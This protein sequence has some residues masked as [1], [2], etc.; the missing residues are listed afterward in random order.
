MSGTRKMEKFEV[1][2]STSFKSGTRKMERLVTPDDQPVVSITTPVASPTPADLAA[3]RPSLLPEERDEAAVAKAE[4]EAEDAD[5]SPPSARSADR[6]PDVEKLRTR[7]ARKFTTLADRVT[8]GFDEFQIGAGWWVVELT[9]PE[10]MS[11]GGGKQVLQHLRLRPMRQGHAVLVGGVV[12]AVDK[13]AELREHAHMDMIYRARFGH[14]LEITAA[15]WEQFLRK[16]E[17]VLRHEQIRT[18][19]VAAPRDVAMIAQKTA[20]AAAA[21]AK[22]KRVAAIA[23]GMSTLAAAFVVWRVLVALWP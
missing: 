11:T 4:A 12:N 9:A 21:A 1:D 10:G 16:A 8:D 15:E 5:P 18:S 14:A 22:K 23:L 2:Q 13:T 17:T 7:L 6:E 19:R 3:A 20:R